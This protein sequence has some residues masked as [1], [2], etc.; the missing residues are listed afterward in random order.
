[1]TLVETICQKGL[2]HGKLHSEA[3]EWEHR[4]VF[5]LSCSLN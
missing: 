3:G 5:P 4:Q 1:M 2:K